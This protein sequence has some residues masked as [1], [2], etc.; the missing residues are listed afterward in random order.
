MMVQKLKSKWTFK[1]LGKVAM[2]VAFT[3]V[4]AIF[5]LA[6]LGT[7]VQA[8]GLVDDT[9]NVANEY[10]RYP[11]ENYQLDFYVD[12]S[13]G[14]LPWNWS[15]GIGKQVMYGL[16]AITNFIWTI[17]LYVSNAT[18]YLV[19][20]AYSLDFI[21]A[22][23]DS[24]GKN[25]QTLAGVTPSGLSTEG[26]YVGFLLL[27]ILVLGIYVAYTG[28]IKR[29]TTKAIHAIVNFVMVF[30]LSAS[31]I[32][33][34][35]D[36]IGKINDFSSDIS[37]A[38]LSLGTKIVMPNSDSKG[39]DSVDLIRD[40]LFSIQVQQPW[41]LLQYNSSDIESIGIDR[42]ES[43]LSTSPDSNN[44]EDREKIVAEEIED[45]SNTNLTITKTINR[46]GTVFFLFV[47]NI[48]ISLFVFLLTGI[49]IF[50]QILF[51]IY[52][53]FLPVSFILS[54]IPSFDGMSKRAIMKLF[55]TILTRAGIT[56]I[57]TTAF[58]ISTMLYSLSGGYPFF[59][60]SFLQIVVFAGIYF[61][62]GD[63][64]SLFSLQS[65]DSQS[66]GSRLMRKPRML[67]HAHMH[68]LQRKL[69]RS[70]TALGAG[71]AIA[72]ATGKKG[73]S[74]TG[75]SASHTSADHSR[76]DGQ[77][78]S[79]L[80]KRIG[81]TI[82]TMADT[83]DRMVDTASGLK[84]QVKDLPT[85]ARHA[86]YQGKSKVKENVRDLTSSISQTKA[87][88]ASGRKEQ[89]EQRRKTIAERRSEMEQV[90]QKKQPASSV[91]E[92]PATKQ[93]QSHDGQTSRQTTVQASHR[94][95]QQTKQE[96]PTVKSDSS[97]LK[98]ERQSNTVQE[99]T[100]QKPVTSTAPTD[101]ASQR[102]VTKGRPSPVQRV[103]S[104]N[105]KNR[106]SLKSAT[107]K[108]GSKKP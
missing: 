46:L 22:T 56:L 44:G 96:R 31:F 87:D 30:I 14:W 92:G 29:E 102:S 72:S 61:K 103:Q 19:Q 76:P 107:I 5:L 15:D 75:S 8:A 12:N 95:S 37:N 48:G 42:V 64:M 71:S 55:N 43:L 68:R 100:V 17:S 101:R 18:G 60:I 2:T 98:T 26:F 90:K 58:S 38:S 32:A 63:L 88:K 82:G 21:S 49:M 25:M 91:H 108:K 6:M 53:M 105:L 97:S 77:E 99:R 50:S 54:M 45:R 70:M 81:Q 93:E 11:L 27:L 62:L 33:Y 57:I 106:P 28:L 89:Q 86:V 10:S 36:Y 9:V 66:V 40:S 47:F 41:L 83:E 16:Y 20:E 39:K 3:L 35:P 84:E 52:A 65:N 78:K 69:G 23:A 94:E 1:R 85:N 51:I 67:M 34:A 104:Q 13:W 7:V 73:Q 24:I 4:I 74:G 80:G 59:L 79:T